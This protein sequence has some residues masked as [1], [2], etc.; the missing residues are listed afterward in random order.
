M[1]FHMLLFFFSINAV[2]QI[3]GASYYEEKI[4]VPSN[5]ISLNSLSF[6]PQYQIPEGSSS[7]ATIPTEE[8]FRCFAED[9]L[10]I[11][12]RKAEQETCIYSFSKETYTQKLTMLC[13]TY[14]SILECFT[15]VD[16]PKVKRVV[17]DYAYTCLGIAFVDLVDEINI[18]FENIVICSAYDT[19]GIVNLQAIKTDLEKSIQIKWLLISKSLLMKLTCG[20]ILDLPTENKPVVESSFHDKVDTLRKQSKSLPHQTMIKIAKNAYDFKHNLGVLYIH[21]GFYIPFVINIK[22]DFD[23][24]SLDFYSDFFLQNGLLV[25]IGIQGHLP[26]NN[27]LLFEESSHCTQISFVTGKENKHPL[28]R[29]KVFE[30]DI[31]PDFLWEQVSYC[32]KSFF[33]YRIGFMPFYENETEKQYLQIVYQESLEQALDRMLTSENPLEYQQN[34]LALEYDIPLTHEESEKGKE[35]D[36]QKERD[37][38]AIQKEVAL[39]MIA[40]QEALK[41]QREKSEQELQKQIFDDLVRKEQQKRSEAVAAGATAGKQKVSKGKGK[42]KEKISKKPVKQATKQLLPLSMKAELEAEARKIV[43][44]NKQEARCKLHMTLSIL[45]QVSKEIDE[46]ASKYELPQENSEHISTKGSHLVG[47][48]DEGALLPFA[49][50]HSSRS[51]DAGMQARHINDFIEHYVDIKLL[52]KAEKLFGIK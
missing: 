30:N 47:H 5:S 46:V 37:E 7:V 27:G 40:Q 38:I 32:T 1:L 18:L 22:N 44:R 33:N 16:D 6:I 49:F 24:T 15:I 13:D 52:K 10:N 36:I 4:L 2:N 11:I 50:S 28:L 51:K 20:G 41:K 31:I 19:S 48:C 45:N 23:I 29:K 26:K 25:F 39:C 34:A 17:K 8:D 14:K 9:L 12:S 43:E 21:E 3:N 35:D 42:G